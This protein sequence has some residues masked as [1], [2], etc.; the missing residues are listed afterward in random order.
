MKK[1]F[2]LFLS[3]L[4]MLICFCVGG[5]AMS[6]NSGMDALRSQFQSGQSKLDY[7]YY[8]PVRDE[9]DSTKYP[10]VV[11]LHG[12]SSGDYPGHQLHRGDCDIALWSGDEFQSRFENAGGAFLLLPRCPTNTAVLAWGAERKDDVKTT[13]DEFVE[14]NPNVD[15]TRIYIGGYSLGGKMVVL[16]A[17]EYPQYFAAAFL[18]SATYPA[19]NSEIESMAQMPVWVFA[20]KKDIKTPSVIYS[21]SV[22]PR[23]DY[24]CSVAANPEHCRITTFEDFYYTNG[25]K[26]TT[27][28]Q[29]HNTWYAVIHDLFMDNGQPFT[30][31]QT[32]DGN[33]NEVTLSRPSGFLSWLSQQST[34]SRKPQEAK[35]SFFE[36]LWEFIMKILSIF[37]D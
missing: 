33:A 1:T 34:E 16:M 32:F 36:K 4:T 13:I 11:W 5:S 22:K 8:S 15:T 9:N 2:L 37:F 7:V 6:I 20:N 17:S 25:D 30:E 12:N 10:L 23:W 29:Q 27:S 24:L 14:E 18:M 21:T 31:S 35:K 26:N 3:V 19:S 28:K